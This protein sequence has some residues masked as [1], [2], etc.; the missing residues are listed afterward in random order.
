MSTGFVNLHRVLHA[1]PVRPCRVVHDPAA[2]VGWIA[3]R[4]FVCTLEHVAVRDR[5]TSRTRFTNVPVGS[6]HAF[7]GER[8][9]HA[10]IFDDPNLAGDMMTPVSGGPSGTAPLAVRPP[11][12]Q[13][14]SDSQRIVGSA[15]WGTI[16]PRGQVR[17]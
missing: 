12:R 8:V 6:G 7:G 10:G 15:C 4:G 14:P 9:D 5:G 17:T 16:S 11:D 2:T 3:F 13:P 1:S